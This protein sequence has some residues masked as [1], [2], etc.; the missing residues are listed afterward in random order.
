[1]NEFDFAGYHRGRVKDRYETQS[2]KNIV[3]KSPFDSTFH[4][5]MVEDS[6]T[7]KWAYCNGCGSSNGFMQRMLLAYLNRRWSVFQ[8]V[9]YWASVP[10][11]GEFK[12]GPP[13]GS[14]TQQVRKTWR[15]VNLRFK[16]NATWLRNKYKELFLET[17]N[18][19]MGWWDDFL[20]RRYA[21]TQNIKCPKGRMNLHDA[22]KIAVEAYYDALEY[23]SWDNYPKQHISEIPYGNE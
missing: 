21:G 12:I 4:L 13:K 23:G 3:N 16:R 11:D 8:N 19:E 9:I 18:E 7:R 1:V 22:L 17:G 6:V 2:I 10:H 5:E 20:L 15:E 14:D